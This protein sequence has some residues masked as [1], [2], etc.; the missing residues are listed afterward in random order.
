[1]KRMNNVMTVRLHEEDMKTVKEISTEY[2]KDQSTIVR[3]LIENGR[4]YFAITQYVN[5]RASLGK[6]AEIAGISISEMMDILAKFGIK[7]NIEMED[8][9]EGIKVAE[10]LFKK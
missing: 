4:V 10:K 1:M 2:K 6:T 3:E 5:R 7:S 8:Y 9:L